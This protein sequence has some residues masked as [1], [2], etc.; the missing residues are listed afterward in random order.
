MKRVSGMASQGKIAA[1]HATFVPFAAQTR[2]SGVDFDGR[3]IRK[4]AAANV[5]AWV[6]ALG[7]TD[8]LRERA[9]AAGFAA[10]A[11]GGSPT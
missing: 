10:T 2:M 9:A 5:K 7:G 3:S 1:P 8:Q 4:G 6:E 11:T